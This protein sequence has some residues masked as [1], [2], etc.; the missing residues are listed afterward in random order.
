MPIKELK[1]ENLPAGIK[2]TKKKKIKYKRKS[3]KIVLLPITLFLLVFSGLAFGISHCQTNAPAIIPSDCTEILVNG[4]N[5]ITTDVWLLDGTASGGTITHW[6]W[7]GTT[8]KGSPWNC[9]FTVSGFEWAKGMIQNTT[10]MGVTAGWGGIAWLDSSCTN[11]ENYSISVGANVQGICTPNRTKVTDVWESLANGSI[12]H[13]TIS[14]GS[15]TI[16]D[17]CSVSGANECYGL[18]CNS[19]A[20]LLY[21][22][23]GYGNKITYVVDRDCNIKATWN[24][25]GVVGTGNTTGID[26]TDGNYFWSWDYVN[27]KIVLWGNES[28]EPT[29]RN[30]GAN[31]TYIG[32]NWSIKLYG[33]VYDACNCS[34][35]WLESNESGSW[36]A[37]TGGTSNV[38]IGKCGEWHNQSFSWKNTTY[39]CNLNVGYRICAMDTAGNSN[40]SEISTFYKM[41][42]LYSISGVTVGTATCVNE[43]DISFTSTSGGIAKATLYGEFH[44]RNATFQ[45]CSWDTSLGTEIKVRNTSRYCIIN[46][47]QEIS[48]GYTIRFYEWKGISRFPPSNLPNALSAIALGIITVIYAYTT[49]R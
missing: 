29:I 4:T 12:Y 7:K 26:T 44:K 42:Y 34:H 38:S 48:S 20:S 9:S 46:G 5:G 11:T 25:S 27:S 43:Y 6:N 45:E 30:V 13:V 32:R 37:L 31:D 40:C 22:D 33:E 18:A 23:C 17:S 47:T 39:Y 36:K 19:D 3:G 10:H 35:V 41:P 21:L 15:G 28:T 24:Q 16:A 1:R 2:K 8:S 14:G 49:R